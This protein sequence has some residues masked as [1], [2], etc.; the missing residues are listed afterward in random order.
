M[1][2][3]EFAVD[4]PAV[5]VALVGGA[6][7]I[8]SHLLREILVR[9]RWKVL[10]VDLDFR[11][12]QDLVLGQ[13]SRLEF[14]H[15]DI[16]DEAVI[17]R[18]SQSDIVV[19]LAAICTP[20]RYM[21]EAQAVIESNFLHPAALAR[22][23]ASSGA[24]LIYFST[25]EVYGK[26]A[27][28]EEILDEDHSD[29]VVGPLGA[30]RWSYAAA[31]QLSER[32]IASLP[33]LRYSIVRPF[34]FIG[35]WMDFMPGIDG[36]GIPRVLASFS[37]ALVRREPLVLVNGGVARRT[38]TAIEDAV[39]FMFCLFRNP[40]KAFGQA[41]NVGNAKNELSIRELAQKMRKIYAELKGFS[42]KDFPEFQIL[43]GEDFYGPGYEDSLRR[44]PS[45]EKAR[46]LLGF[47]AKVSLQTALTASLAWFDSH[48][49]S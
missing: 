8:G 4:S 34:N 46:R 11:R 44:I 35:P 15:A 48:Y 38:F 7:F 14:L 28:A 24:W 41:F 47:E 22:A 5:K 3:F 33:G 23:C 13:S 12:T 16:A 27:A 39:E 10:V 9:T 25:S 2:H 49:S 29:F 1:S 6:G 17:R 45:V 21:G 37:S 42:E 43:S 26:T 18:V 20:S 32:Y 36:E 30:S 31:K 40:A 19:N